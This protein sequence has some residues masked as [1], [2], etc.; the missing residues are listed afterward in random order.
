[1]SRFLA[2]NEFG[3]QVLNKRA[4][5]AYAQETALKSVER[6]E[7]DKAKQVDTMNRLLSST[8]GVAELARIE[9]DWEIL[10]IFRDSFTLDF[11]EFR[12]LPLG[13]VPIYRTRV[14]NPVGLFT[15]SLAGVGGTV[16][17][18]TKDTATQ[19]LP[20]TYS[21]ER[22]MVPNLNNLYDME[23]L[24]QRRDALAQLD[25]YD[26]IEMENIG[27]NTVFATSGTDVVSTDPATQIVTYFNAGGS[28]AGHNVY[29]LDPGVPSAAVP[30]VNIYDLSAELGL[31]KKVFRTVNTHSIQIGRNFSTM[32]I[33]QAA[34]SGN[35]PVWES[36]Q[37]LAT[38][39]ALIT[40]SGLN[41][42]PAAAVPSEMWAEFQKDDFRGA[43]VVEWF[44][45]RIA[46]KKLNWLPAGY[47]ILFADGHP[48]CMI[49]KRL[50]LS[51]AGGQ[52]GTLTE[53]KDGF[54]SYLSKSHNIATARADFQLRNF[55]LLKLQS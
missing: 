49:W 21:T 8:A 16:Y 51:G 37:N 12:N 24:M 40:G 43:V 46:I 54:Y 31:T 41:N 45:Q 53:P 4:F 15:G 27:L 22:V 18:A 19:V 42:N 47:A 6:T 25:R 33:P 36:L 11:A 2:T 26:N 48:A 9:G 7:E 39:V 13:T 30:T 55:L 5:A 38:P 23:R 29:S 52:E 20:F 50:D 44:G 28:F 10:N 17:W 35:A 32:W 34:T 14:L 1:M 3:D